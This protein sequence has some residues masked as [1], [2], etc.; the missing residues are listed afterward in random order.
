MGSPTN[1]NQITNPTRAVEVRIWLEIQAGNAENMT[2]R[3]PDSK[4]VRKLDMP[5]PDLYFQAPAGQCFKWVAA[6]EDFSIYEGAGVGPDV[7]SV[8]EALNLREPTAT[9]DAH[10]GR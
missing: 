10:C 8:E 4:L 7:E 1:R 5:D 2:R 6:H 3:I 9:V